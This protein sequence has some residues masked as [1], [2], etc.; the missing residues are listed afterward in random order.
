MADDAFRVIETDTTTGWDQYLSNM[1]T[2]PWSDSFTREQAE[3]SVKWREE[4]ITRRYA[5]KIVAAEPWMSDNDETR[6]RH[7]GRQGRH[8]SRGME[9]C[10]N[11]DCREASMRLSRDAINRSFA[12][13]DAAEAST[14]DTEGTCP[15]GC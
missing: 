14:G 11:I 10:G 2:S 15:G 1:S 13:A 5:Y 9:D 12:A 7:D 6:K 3:A 8:G 4:N